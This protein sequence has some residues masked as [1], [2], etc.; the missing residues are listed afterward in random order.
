MYAASLV[1]SVNK[2]NRIEILSFSWLLVFIITE[3]LP[4]SSIIFEG[5]ILNW[6]G[7]SSILLKYL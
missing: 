5:G 6:N 7:I 3:F 1:P 2:N 4:F